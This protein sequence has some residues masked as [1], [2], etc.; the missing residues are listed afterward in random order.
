MP[1]LIY[2]IDDDKNIRDLIAKYIAKEGY[3][4]KVFESG[5]NVLK[6][7][8]SDKPDMLILDIMM[9]GIDGFELCKT[10]RKKSDVPIII[11][12]ARDEDLDKILGLELGSDDY[13]AKPFS[14]RELIARI[15]SIFRRVKVQE[16]A[17]EIKVKDIVIIPDERRV[18]YNGSNVDFSSMEFELVYFLSKNANKAYTRDQLLER[19]WGYDCA[20]ETRAVDDMVKR[21]RKKLQTY[22][23]EFNITTIW[24]YGYKVES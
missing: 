7:F 21:I 2:V 23:C 18:L 9:P 19:V 12:S 16:K 15:K 14:P 4:V 6:S 1:E 22:G 24:G 5:E 13:I 3:A 10:I 8:D 20:I 17:N 11:V